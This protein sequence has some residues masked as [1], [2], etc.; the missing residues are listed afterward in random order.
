MHWH[1]YQ[2]SIL[3]HITYCH[4]PILI[5]MMKDHGSSLNTIFTY[6][7]IINMIQSLYNIASSSIGN[8]CWPMAM[9]PNGIEFGVMD[10]PHNLR[11]QS[12]GFL[13][14]NIQTLLKDARFYGASLEMD[15]AK[16]CMMVLAQ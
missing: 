10:V 4:N 6:L 5:P 16:A 1:S 3:M 7:M 14:S 8:T 9:H 13:S 2:I 12:H 11:I 15:M